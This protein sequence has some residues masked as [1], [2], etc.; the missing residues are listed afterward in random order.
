MLVAFLV[1]NWQY[2]VLAVLISYFAYTFMQQ[3]QTIAELQLQ[4][5]QLEKEKVEATLAAEREQHRLQQEI[6]EKYQKHVQDLTNALKDVSIQ[7][8]LNRNEL[9]SLRK[10][11]SAN[12]VSI[13]TATRDSLI[14]YTETLTELFEECSSMV[15]DLAAK[16]DEASLTANTYYTILEDVRT[17]LKVSA[18]N[19]R[20]EG[21]IVEELPLQEVAVKE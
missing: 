18:E 5:L 1:K 19:A 10:I 8:T 12:K 9:D 15:T 6:S 7:Y 21:E 20:K 11:T 17:T 2:L 16:A 14:P 4:N 13:P 3:K